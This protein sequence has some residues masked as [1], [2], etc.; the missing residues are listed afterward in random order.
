[1]VIATAAH[2]DAFRSALEQAGIGVGRALEPWTPRDSASA[3]GSR[4]PRVTPGMPGQSS[5]PHYRGHPRDFA[6]IH[7][8]CRHGLVS[9]QPTLGG[10][11]SPCKRVLVT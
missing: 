1:V 4:V 10:P 2:N 6:A 11:T 3:A 5:I 7:S 9:S 8:R